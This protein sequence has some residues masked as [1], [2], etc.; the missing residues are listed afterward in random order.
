[1]E[2][3]RSITGQANISRIR[4]R[5]ARPSSRRK[6]SDT[7]A[8]STITAASAKV[9]NRQSVE[10]PKFAKKRIR[11]FLHSLC[12][13]ELHHDLL[14][15]CIGQ[16]NVQEQYA[17]SDQRPQP[18]GHFKCINR[19]M[20]QNGVYNQHDFKISKPAKQQ[21]LPPF[22]PKAV[23][24]CPGRL[25]FAI[26]DN[27]Q[28]GFF[29]PAQSATHRGA[30][31]PCPQGAPT[32]NSVSSGV[33]QEMRLHRAATTGSKAGLQR[34]DR[35]RS[36]ARSARTGAPRFRP[37]AACLKVSWRINPLPR[38]EQVLLPSPSRKWRRS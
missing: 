38:P 14:R 35:M 30:R 31:T 26:S 22:P 29:K 2:K 36:R 9:R 18:H 23:P 17:Q 1:M 28:H 5:S 32:R 10:V 27:I 34:A 6:G 20:K 12:E 25:S 3:A 37:V 16:D 24:E 8:K 21:R 15:Q 7:G 19:A 33:R 13:A 4:D 11:L